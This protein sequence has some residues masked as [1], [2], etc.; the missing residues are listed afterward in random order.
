MKPEF[1]QN[2]ACEEHNVSFGELEPRMF[3]FNNPIGA[4]PVCLGLGETSVISPSK[5]IP[6]MN[7]SI[8]QGAIAVNGFKSLDEK[9]Y[10]GPLFEAAGKKYGFDFDKPIKDYSEKALQVLLYGSGDEKYKVTREF[11]GIVRRQEITFDGVVGMINQ[12]KAMWKEDYYDEFYEESPCT[13]CGGCRR[14]PRS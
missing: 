8:R 5:I 2:Y 3:S 12:R 7:L 10:S 14:A 4:C 13:A 6:D 1:S 9:A 11:E